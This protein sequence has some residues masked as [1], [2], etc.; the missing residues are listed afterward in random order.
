M[1]SPDQFT[2]I[3][4]TAVIAIAGALVLIFRSIATAIGGRM[5]GS[6]AS[7]DPEVLAE[8]DS[9]K[10][11]LAE[12]EERLDFSERLLANVRPADPVQ[13]RLQQ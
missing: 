1:A 7:P 11:R 4:L 3:D 12:V 13:G 2:V 5:R 8:I 6:V 10:G 9:L